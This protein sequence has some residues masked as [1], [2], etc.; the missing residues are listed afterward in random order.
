MVRNVHRRDRA[1]DRSACGELSLSQPRALA[2]GLFQA[3]GVGG[4]K[5]R[6]HAGANAH[7]SNKG[8]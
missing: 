5:G 3:G 1:L 6:T 2:L 4:E 8:A 7:T